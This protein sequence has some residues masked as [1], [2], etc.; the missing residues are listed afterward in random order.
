MN[1]KEVREWLYEAVNT[2]ADPHDACDFDGSDVKA[3]RQTIDDALGIL[4]HVAENLEE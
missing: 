3:L 1:V 4:K 2:L